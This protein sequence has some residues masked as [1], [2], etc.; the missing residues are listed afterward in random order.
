[1][2]VNVL[3]FGATLKINFPHCSLFPNV[4]RETLQILLLLLKPLK[5]F[6][7]FALALLSP[8]LV[9]Q[10]NIENGYVPFV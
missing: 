5:Y 8:L 4:E 7:N 3:Y 6:I 10:K 9:Q 2:F 1:M